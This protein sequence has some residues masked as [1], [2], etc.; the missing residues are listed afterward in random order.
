MSSIAM[1]RP[2]LPVYLKT[3]YAKDG[4]YSRIK[5]LF[6]IHNLAY[7]GVFGKK[8]YPKLGLDWSLFKMDGPEFYDKD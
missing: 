5:T 6:T 7:Q 2:G 4:F 1:I 3:V 8:E